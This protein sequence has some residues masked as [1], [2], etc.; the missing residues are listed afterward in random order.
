MKQ[1]PTAMA[2]AGARLLRDRRPDHR[3]TLLVLGTAHF[4]NPRRDFI[5]F[6]VEDVLA[7]RRQRE[8]V[9]LVEQLATFRPTH[10]AVEFPLV[11]QDDLD[12][13][14]QDLR[15]DRYQLSRNEV[16]QLGL[17]LAAT[18]GLER[19]CAVDWNEGPPG[20]VEHYDWGAYA[21][22]HGQETFL[23]AMKDP[24][25]AR[26]TCPPL[27]EQTIVGWIRELNEPERLAASHR[28]HF[29]IASI[30][31]EAQQP[32][33]NWVGHWYARNL[34]IFWNL[35][36]LT[37]RPEDRVLVV[38]GQGHAYLLRQFAIESGAFRLIDVAQVLQER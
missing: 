31:D 1:L 14:Y 27:G 11:R 6:E 36:R 29:D 12:K 30:G 5:N 18:L 2:Q 7:D 3:P 22:S 16:D 19:I 38:C 15:K 24:Q 34:R 8:I 10:V 21:Q 4:A 25:Y 26:S 35:V 37:E 9:A 33:A 28:A 17:R 23:S 13:R 20:D 32:G